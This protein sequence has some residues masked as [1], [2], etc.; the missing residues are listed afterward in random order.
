MQIA[1]LRR[2]GE[3]EF[4]RAVL[5]QTYCSKDLAIKNLHALTTHEHAKHEGNEKKKRYFN[6]LK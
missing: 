5:E 4:F 2:R 3:E 1:S 6:S